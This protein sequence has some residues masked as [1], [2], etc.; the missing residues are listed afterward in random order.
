V[1]EKSITALRLWLQTKGTLPNFTAIICDRLSAWRYDRPNSV[2]MSNCPGLKRT[3]ETQ[4]QLGWRCL[5]EGVPAKGWAE[6]Q[7]AYFGRKGSR[8]SGKRWLVAVLKKLSDIA[9]DQWEHRNGI[10][11]DKEI[12]TRTIER[13]REIREQFT[14][15]SRTVMK[16]DQHF[17]TK[18]ADAVL[19]LAEE[20]QEAWLVRVIASR[21]RYERT[22]RRDGFTQERRGM[23]AWLGRA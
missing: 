8:R 7:E 11:H 17:L 5:L 3:I 9:W 14:I 13:E 16:E 21:G 20:V 23:F 15:G 2:P 1:W 22:H 18:G 10:S 4:D 19:D 6:I 12:G